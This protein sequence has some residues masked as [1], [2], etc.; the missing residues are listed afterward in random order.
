VI[1]APSLERLVQLVLWL[2]AGYHLALGA[3]ALV[4]PA[5]AVR[6]MRSLYGAELP[7]GGAFRY[8]TSMIG[9]LAVA[10]GCLAAAAARAPAEHRAVV[11]A[12]LLLQLC[13]IFC[14]LRDRGLLAASLGVSARRNGAAVVVLGAECLLLGLWLR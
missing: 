5:L 13:R 1:G 11:G 8:M 14:R 10:I 12:L 2:L 3:A 6:L 7:E 4:A 9:A